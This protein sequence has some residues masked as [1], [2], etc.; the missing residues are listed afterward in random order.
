[1]QA[2][3]RKHRNITIG[4]VQECKALIERNGC[5]YYR[6]AKALAVRAWV[7][8]WVCCVIIHRGSPPGVCCPSLHAVPPLCAVHRGAGRRNPCRKFGTSRTSSTLVNAAPRARTSCRGSCWR[9]LASCSA[10]TTTWW[11]LV[12]ELP[13][14]STSSP[15]SVA[16]GHRWRYLPWASILTAHCCCLVVWCGVPLAVLWTLTTGGYFR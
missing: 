6:R 8:V 4:R 13:W 2:L 3:T 10:R 9:L 5:E 1:M 14:T 7:W 11:T 16:V 12:C 15:V